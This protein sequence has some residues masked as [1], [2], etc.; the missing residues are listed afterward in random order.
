VPTKLSLH[1]NVS[2]SDITEELFSE[3]GIK[4]ALPEKF[5]NGNPLPAA[6]RRGFLAVLDMS[7]SLPSAITLLVTMVTIV[8]QM[9][10]V[11]FITHIISATHV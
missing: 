3:T 10:F 8:T 1:K 4:H 11:S 5:S 2:P 7:L 6:E 9:T